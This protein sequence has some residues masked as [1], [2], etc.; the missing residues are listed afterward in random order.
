M[1]NS[2]VA[3][4]FMDIAVLLDMDDVKFKPRA[5]ENAARAIESLDRD[6]A[7]IYVEGGLDALMEIPGV[8]ESI[9]K[10][11]EELLK[12]G[13]LKYYE[14]LRRQVPVNIESLTSVEGL[15]PK[16]IKELYQRLGVKTLEDLEAAAR[17]GRI[18]GIPG[19]GV[20]REANILRSIDALKSSRGRFLL[21]DALPVIK[22]ILNRF[23]NMEAVKAIEVSG[24]VRRWKETVGD[25]DFLVISDQP[26]N[27]MDAFVSLPQVASIHSHG[28]TRSSVRLKS[29]M[30]ADVRVIPEQSFGAALQYFTGSKPHNIALRRI[31]IA[32]G[33]K[34]SEYGLF[35]GREQIAGATEEDVYG[36]LGLQWIPPELRENKGEIEA[37]QQG[38]LPNLVKYSDVKGDLQVH[39]SWTDGMNSIEDMANEAL[40][41]DLEYIAITDHTKGLTVVHGLDEARIRAQMREIDKLNRS[42]SGIQ[43]LKGCEANIQRDGSLDLDDSTLADLDVVGAAVHSYWTLPESE[44]TERLIKVMENDNVDFI[45]HPTSRELGKR[46]AIQLD[47]DRI[48]QAAKDTGT[49]LEIDAYPNRLDLKDDYVRRCVEAGVKMSIDTDAHALWHLHFREFGVA[50][51]RRGWATSDDIVNTHSV[52]DILDMFK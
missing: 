20:K 51:A 41:T 13:H 34:L 23:K 31:A 25:A 42:L 33:R 14:Y 3:E 30:N 38:K 19:F 50:V 7:E 48:I 10:K 39:T 5:Y 12:T 11:I 26:A 9:A 28:I 6:L 18:R 22:S 35:E 29:N 15:G 27:I 46:P 24:S 16:T 36:K 43:I 47:F 52:K 44:Q 32:R 40:K 8:G 4:V 2:E 37:A 49:I 17:S 45:I 1:S 21:G